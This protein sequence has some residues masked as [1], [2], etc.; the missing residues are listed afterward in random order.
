MFT[1]ALYVIFIFCHF[2]LCNLYA[3]GLIERGRGSYGE[4]AVGSW[5]E[6]TKV[7]I[8]NFCSIAQ[9]VSIL[10]GGGH[11]TDWV[12][13]Y[14]FSVLWPSVAGHIPGHPSTKGDVII[15]NDVWIGTGALILSGVTIGDGVVIGAHAVVA[16]D[17]PAY[18]I[19]VGNP[20]KVVKFR[21]D[22]ATI[23][24]LLAIAWWNWPDEKI[25][26]AVEL[27]LS[28]DINEFIKQYE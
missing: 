9:G 8:G 22:E 20:A 24:K 15:G 3:S 6:G 14:P 4:P 13:T 7:K 12:T 2:Q 1:K 18:A 26:S 16:K 10:L 11:R 25:A 5:G 19:A 21:F 23:E 27:M 28:N 17:V